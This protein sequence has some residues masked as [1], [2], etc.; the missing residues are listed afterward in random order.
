MSY[1]PLCQKFVPLSFSYSAYFLDK[2]YIISFMANINARRKMKSQVRPLSSSGITSSSL[3][4][5]LEFARRFTTRDLNSLTTYGLTTYGR[6]VELTGT[7]GSSTAYSPN[8]MNPPPV[9][10]HINHAVE[11]NDSV[12]KVDGIV[13]PPNTC[14]LLLLIAFSCRTCRG[15]RRRHTYT[16]CKRTTS[17][18]RGGLSITGPE[19]QGTIKRF[20][21]LRSADEERSHRFFDNTSILPTNR[22][23]LPFLGTCISPPPF[24]ASIAS[25]QCAIF[26]WPF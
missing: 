10:F 2:M 15:P 23:T 21:R 12:S 20:S 14:Y 16:R 1:L 22:N 18:G 4:G 25:L 19:E 9:N 8:S 13:F 7:N 24:Y 3:G 11:R 6:D 26:C 5:P 17:W